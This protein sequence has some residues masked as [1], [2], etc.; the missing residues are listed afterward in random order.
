MLCAADAGSDSFEAEW[1]AAID[2]QTKEQ[3]PTSCFG[4]RWLLQSVPVLLAVCVLL[5]AVRDS[6]TSYVD[7]RP[8]SSSSPLWTAPATSSQPVEQ[9]RPPRNIQPRTYT[10][11]TLD[12][13]QLASLAALYAPTSS[14]PELFSLSDS[15]SASVRSLLSCLDSSNA[16]P[17]SASVSGPTNQPTS[18]SDSSPRPSLRR[19]AVV[20]SAASAPS[21]A[22]LSLALRS[23]HWCVLVVGP[24]DGG[25][26]GSK[27]SGALDSFRRRLST[28]LNES[29]HWTDN[30]SSTQED[31][32]TQRLLYLSVDELLSL[33][34]AA[35][36]RPR[37]NI[38]VEQGPLLQQAKSI[39]YTLAIHAGVD[40]LYDSE[41]GGPVVSSSDLPVMTTSHTFRTP[42]FRHRT[43]IQ[44]TLPLANNDE[45]V[46]R[47]TS[48]LS[49]VRPASFA[50]TTNNRP[51]TDASPP[52]AYYNVSVALMNPYAL[53]GHTHLWPRGFP[54]LHAQGSLVGRLEVPLPP[55]AE[56]HLNYQHYQHCLPAI[57]QLVPKQQS[58]LDLDHYGEWMAVGMRQQRYNMSASRT[59]PFEPQDG[60]VRLALAFRS[61]SPFSAQSSIWLSS[62]LPSLLL[63]R[64]VPQRV[65]DI[66]RGYIA[67]TL[68]SYERVSN[69]PYNASIRRQERPKN[70]L[71]TGA[72]PVSLLASDIEP[73]VAYA[74]VETLPDTART[75]SPNV[76]HPID[77]PF[78]DEAERLIALLTTRQHGQPF[79]LLT[80]ARQRAQPHQYGD[81]T[82]LHLLA[83]LYAD[84]YA[85]GVVEWDDV[86]AAVDWA[87]DLLRITATREQHNAE[88]PQRRDEFSEPPYPAP[89][90]PHFL[91]TL[92]HRQREMAV[93]VNFNWPP[94]DNTLWELLRYYSLMHDQV[95]VILPVPFDALPSHQQYWLTHL[96][97][98]VHLLLSV[99]EDEGKCQQYSLLTCLQWANTS[100]ALEGSDVHGVLYTADDLWF[101]FYEVLHPPPPEPGALPTFTN[102][103]LFHTHLTYPLDEFWYPLPVMELN[104]SLPADRTS[105]WEW[106]NGSKGPYFGHLKHVWRAWPQQWRDLLS[107]IT[108]VQDSVVTNAVADMVYVPKERRQLHSLL[109]ILRYTLYDIPQPPGCVFSE[110]LLTQLIHLSML[111]SDVR[112]AI[113]LPT[114]GA[115][116]DRQYETLY[117]G[118]ERNATTFYAQ[119]HR[120]LT[121]PPS[122]PNLVPLPPAQSA[123]VRPVPLRIDGYRWNRDDVTWMRRI[124]IG[125]DGDPVFLHPVK[126]GGRMGGGTHEGYVASMERMLWRMDEARRAD[127]RV[128]NTTRLAE[129]VTSR[130]A[131]S[132]T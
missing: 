8:R 99:E 59:G 44:H 30:S 1:A 115:D 69:R 107:S 10:P 76:Q 73:C 62:A 117:F 91:P 29:S 40:V 35:S 27:V 79:D 132:V 128:H 25:A 118:A 110:V 63:P 82:Q 98:E 12:V 23:S 77:R 31:R 70:D 80:R 104:M 131:D 109:H 92:P 78:A 2:G 112:P 124:L 58:S 16:R 88:E 108:G 75:T 57:Q 60:E 129:T 13:S 116:Y 26:F 50:D 66:W 123:R 105:N 100:G 49:S 121:L 68:L 32:L 103:S 7:L 38:S 41:D 20:L 85:T 52:S 21:D 15:S 19:V 101:D 65:S 97:P 61:Y 4:R 95:A 106:L 34:Y 111:L 64:T 43:L 81:V 28:Q 39:A 130:G 14:L 113:P 55:L 18:K 84:L 122:R 53:L 48:N 67:E 126:L 42:D 114:A 87:T 125:G 94:G 9:L 71:A 37:V 54:T 93:C 33:P 127:G 96:F 86:Q 90:P 45:R 89:L 17:P 22:S 6:L 46:K 3:Q 74:Q 5:S 119:L 11:R 102:V 24:A 56:Y 120:F 36:S 72:D 47:L 51:S 83:E